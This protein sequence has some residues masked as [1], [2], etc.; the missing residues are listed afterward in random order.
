MLVEP[1]KSPSPAYSAEIV[2]KPAGSDAVLKLALPL[3]SA[4]GLP[5]ATPFVR[6][7]MFPVGVAVAGAMGLIVT[8]K[9][10]FELCTDGFWD[11]TRAAIESATVISNMPV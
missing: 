10:T 3:M 2:F 6:K 8:T 5:A 1:E 4:I 9:V 7:R 11:E